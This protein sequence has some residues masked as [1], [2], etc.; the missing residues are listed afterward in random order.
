M[1]FPR[2]K[3]LLEKI[4]S[5]D[6]SSFT[7]MI[8]RGLGKVR[9]FN[10][11]SRLL[12]WATVVF[13]L[14]L[15]LSTV[16]IS[17]Y[18]GELRSNTIQ[19]DLLQQLQNEIEDTK[20]TLYRAR[21][22]LKF[23]E[24]YVGNPQ[25]KQEKQVESHEPGDI[26]PVPTEPVIQEETFERPDEAD[27]AESAVDIKNLT[28]RW[29]GERLSVKFRL[30]KILPNRNQLKGYIF[31]IAANSESDPPQLWTHPR[32]ALKN[33]EPINYKQ[34][35]FFKVRNYRIIRGKYFLD[36][37]TETPSFLKILVYDESGKLILKKEFSIEVAP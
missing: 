5:S 35:Q 2:V 21:Q 18:F 13:M 30:I 10:I 25:G 15:V 8:S 22:R 34:G 16:A 32:A 29:R 27:P 4:R 20:R 23:L 33:G 26:N 14:Y 17:R 6:S 12:F 1:L 37:K 19:L 9:G 28:T 3:Q 7:V 36:S 11:S 24:E 31:M